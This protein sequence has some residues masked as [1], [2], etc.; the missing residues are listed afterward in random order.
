MDRLRNVSFLL[1]A[2]NFLTFLR[3]GLNPEKDKILEIAVC[4]RTYLNNYNVT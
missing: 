3:T 4:T 1:P 2:R